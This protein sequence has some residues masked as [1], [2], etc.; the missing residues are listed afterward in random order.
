MNS[1]FYKY[2]LFK[3]SVPFGCISIYKGYRP[4][5]PHTPDVYIPCEGRKPSGSVPISIWLP[6]V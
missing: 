1:E 4:E 2:R 6:A 5:E 3:G